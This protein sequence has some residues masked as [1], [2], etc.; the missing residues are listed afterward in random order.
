[1]KT[2][3]LFTY[4]DGTEKEEQRPEQLKKACIPAQA[5]LVIQTGTTLPEGNLNICMKT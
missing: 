4:H 2:I 3:T 5:L 1:M